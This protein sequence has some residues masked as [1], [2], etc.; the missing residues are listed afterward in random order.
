MSKNTANRKAIREPIRDEIR[1]RDGEVL[2]RRAMSEGAVSQF[3]VPDSLKESGWDLQWVRTAC[4]GKDD[5]ANVTNHM[6]NGWR[7][8]PGNRPGFK[9]FFRTDGAATIDREGLMLMERPMTLTKQAHDED[10]RNSMQQRNAQVEEFA[11]SGLPSGFDRG[12]GKAAT[13]VN[14]SVE[15]AP[16]DSYPTRELSV[17]D[18]E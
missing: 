4:L 12:Y 1:G 14:R 18:D 8:V 11:L 16:I 17:G 15:G 10:Y 3:H 7:A 6:E 9:D 5:P 13:R 2:T